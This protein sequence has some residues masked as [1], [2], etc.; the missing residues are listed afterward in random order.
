METPGSVI[1]SGKYVVHINPRSALDDVDEK[2]YLQ[3]HQPCTNA[4][5][6]FQGKCKHCCNVCT[7]HWR[8][9]PDNPFGPAGTQWTKL[10]GSHLSKDH[11]IKPSSH[12]GNGTYKGPF[13]FTIT[14]SPT[15]DLS[16]E[17]MIKAVTKVMNQKSCPTKRFIWYIEYGSR[18]QAEDGA[19]THPHIHGMYET[20]TGGRIEK[21]HWKRAWPIWDEGMRMGLGF[22][23]GY[24]RKVYAE[25]N[26]I[27]YVKK[28]ADVR[29]GEFNLNL[30][31]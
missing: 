1:C 24:H 18:E 3:K 22:R 13:A 27:D 29:H 16:E 21:K 11:G 30:P 20:E 23:G 12:E 4:E 5:F 7:V 28:C 10:F 9:M 15:D 14:K 17:D 2:R 8:N 25:E 31:L 19:R 26:Y 6:L